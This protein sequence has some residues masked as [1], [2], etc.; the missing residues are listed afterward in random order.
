[1]KL[2]KPF[3]TLARQEGGAPM[4]FVVTDARQRLW[5]GDLLDADKGERIPATRQRHLC[6]GK[7]RGLREACAAH[8]A[9]RTA[10]R[11]GF[12]DKRR[13]IKDKPA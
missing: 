9:A 6:I 13:F 1:M 11:L 5:Q 2:A 7:W 12:A 8:A 4:L 3:Y 10:W